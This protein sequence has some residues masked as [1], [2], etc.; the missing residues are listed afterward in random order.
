MPGGVVPRFR[1]MGGCGLCC[2]QWELWPVLCLTT[3]PPWVARRSQIQTRK[4]RDRPFTFRAQEWRWRRLAIAL[5]AAC[6]VL[7]SV[8]VV[9]PPAGLRPQ[10]QRLITLIAKDSA[11]SH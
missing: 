11:A 10:Q 7:G 9:L 6:I 8:A 1:C 5:L 3:P 2:S 4:R